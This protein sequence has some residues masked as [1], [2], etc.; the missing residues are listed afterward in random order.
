MRTE[1]KNLIIK[2]EENHKLNLFVRV[3]NLQEF[4]SH[5]DIHNTVNPKHPAYF[6]ILKDTIHNDYNLPPPVRM[7]P[8]QV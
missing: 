8:W 5:G 6:V 4:Y 1:D 3:Q 2:D 7:I